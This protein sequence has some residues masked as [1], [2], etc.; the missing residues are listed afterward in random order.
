MAGV[1]TPDTYPRILVNFSEPFGTQGRCFKQ[2]LHAYH[3]MSKKKIIEKKIFFPK[4]KCDFFEKIENFQ[5]FGAKP[6]LAV[7]KTY[8]GCQRPI[9]ELQSCSR[10]HSKGN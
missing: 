6:G 3:H 2:W 1:S 10:A 4:K 8:F 5:N 7:G 9:F